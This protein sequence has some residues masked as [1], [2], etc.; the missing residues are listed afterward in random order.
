[1]TADRLRPL[2]QV[3]LPALV[4]LRHDLHRHPELSNTEKRTSGVVQ[5]ELAALGI[6]F[7]AGFG[8]SGTGIVAHIP[9]TTP[10]NASRP[11]TALRADMDALPIHEETG[12][13]YASA[14]AGVM[15]ACGHDGHTTI[16]LGAARTLLRLD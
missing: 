3:E 7:K 4:K 15:H 9:P 16:L 5:R 11:A 12:R 10:G 6:A 1:M 13:P 8:A 2:I 14:S